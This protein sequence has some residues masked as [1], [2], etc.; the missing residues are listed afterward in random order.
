LTPKP[1]KERTGT[2]GKK[3]VR[4][5]IKPHE[6]GGRKKLEGGGRRVK[7]Q[8]FYQKGLSREEKKEA[9]KERWSVLSSFPRREKRRK[10]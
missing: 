6:R 5:E 3:G 8:L 2:P 1:V 9:V 10:K 7:V 4:P